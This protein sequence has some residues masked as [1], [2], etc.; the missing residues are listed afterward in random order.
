MLRKRS[1]IGSSIRMKIDRTPQTSDNNSL[2]EIRLRKKN[3][4]E[5]SI[6]G[7]KMLY[8]INSV[9]FKINID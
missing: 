9:F 7:K 2:S 8:F 3:L 5:N 6:I 4:L 1:R